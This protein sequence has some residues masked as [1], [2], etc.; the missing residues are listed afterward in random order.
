MS[1]VNLTITGAHYGLLTIIIIIP[2]VCL[3]VGQIRIQY[4]RIHLF[5]SSRLA[6]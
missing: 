3:G 5:D 6:N 2:F 4:V 1:G